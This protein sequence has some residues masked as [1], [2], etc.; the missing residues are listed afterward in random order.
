MTVGTEGEP[1]DPFGYLY[2][3]GPG[4][5]QGGGQAAPAGFG[6]SPVQ[7][8]QTRYGQPQP[9]AQPPNPET[10]ATQALPGAM[11]PAPESQPGQVPPQRRDGGGHGGGSR[12]T[13]RGGRGP[14]IG[15]LV[16]VVVVVAVIAAVVLMN[17]GDDDK[18]GAAESPPP[19]APSAP[20][21][22]APP[23]SA[24]PSKTGPA[25]YGEIE[26]E[27]AQLSGGAATA[28][29]RKGFTGT[30]FV[31]NLVQGS[32]VSWTA[33]VPD[34]GQY[35][36]KLMYGNGDAS[37]K[38]ADGNRPFRPLVVSINGKVSSAGPIKLY[39]LGNWDNFGM[40][41]GIV[42]LQE[43]VNTLTLSCTEAGGCPVNVDSVSVSKTKP[44]S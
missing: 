41:W 8:G 26:A 17:S 4:D 13:S 2:R 30:G 22:S 34:A 31:N 38:G 39:A 35:Y 23:S 20:P 7:V 18:K 44:T 32:S 9:Y 21:S 27:N 12:G 15:A 6:S 42:T 24:P 36:L 19:S 33:D 37:T 28:S 1:D 5:A 3:P 25:V 40:T 16:A 11:P 29:D 14:V 10:Q 43:G